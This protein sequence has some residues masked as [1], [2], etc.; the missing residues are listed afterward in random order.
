MLRGLATVAIVALLALDLLL[1][2]T[3]LGRRGTEA[4]T[5]LDQA[6][7][8]RVGEPLPPFS[9]VALDTPGGPPVRNEDLL[10]HRVLLTFE[11]SVD[12]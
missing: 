8:A 6:G 1:P 11:R 7:A 9:L 3:S 12:W 4:A 5:R 2:R 10:G